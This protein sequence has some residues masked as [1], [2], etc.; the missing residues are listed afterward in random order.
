MYTLLHLALKDAGP[1]R[2]VVVCDLQDVGSIDPVVGS[3]S[4]AVVTFAV[5]LIDR[6]LQDGQH[7]LCGVNAVDNSHYYMSRNTPC[8]P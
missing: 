6:N 1:A 4:H 2:L 3:A 7:G 8:P 5:E